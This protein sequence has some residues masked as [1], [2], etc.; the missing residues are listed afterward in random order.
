MRNLFL[1]ASI[2]LSSL[3]PASAQQSQYTAQQFNVQPINQAP[4]VTGAQAVSDFETGTT[5]RYYWIITHQ[6]SVISSPVQ[7]SNT[8]GP[9]SLSSAVGSRVNVTWN[10]VQG[11]ATYDVL[12]T[13]TPSLPLLANCAC[14]VAIGITQNAVTDVGTY[15]A[16]STLYTFGQNWSVSQ[17]IV[18]GIP[19]YNFFYNGILACSINAA[20]T[21]TCATSSGGSVSSVGFDYTGPEFSIAN[22]PV[23]STG[24]LTESKTV[25][26]P[27]TVWA[28]PAANSVNGVFDNFAFSI[29]STTV[30]T[31]STTI[32]PN[33]NRDVEIFVGET[34]HNIGQGGTPTVTGGGTW[35]TIGTDGNDGILASQLLTSTAPLTATI[36]NIATPT[37]IGQCLV[38]LQVQPAA[39]PV[40]SNTQTTSGAITNGTTLAYT[41]TAAGDSVMVV[42]MGAPSNSNTAVS[43]L[44]TDDQ[45]T[46][47]TPVCSA[48]NFT[49][50]NGTIVYVFLAS[51]V[52]TTA[53]HIKF[54]AVTGPGFSGSFYAIEISELQPSTGTSGFRPL[55]TAD[56]PVA[57]QSLINN[58]T[59]ATV[60]SSKNLASNVAFSANTTTT[61]DSITVNQAGGAAPAFPNSTATFRVNVCY[62]YFATAGTGV[63]GETEVSDGT[64][65]WAGGGAA[66]SSGGTTYTSCGWSPVTYTSAGVITFTVSVRNTG[67]QTI[68]T[69]S[70][71]LGQASHMSV[72]VI[73]SN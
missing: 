19:T 41:P 33:Y 40:F 24:V 5:V 15:S 67:S 70:P 12:E 61:I 8:R 45:N 52:T 27:N 34:D 9:A 69:T 31:L 29:S 35:T 13:S 68:S 54:N 1:I 37:N 23:T 6:N 20:G 43:Y 7:T 39:T 14:A 48:Q 65:V 55:V 21:T 10:N 22:S 51:N 16:Y 56:M 66:T 64:N 2:F 17:S 32:T 38:G 30:T 49:G 62:S 18:S 50:S 36:G 4:Q 28:G 46:T 3:L 42:F 59:P 71:I 73:P 58:P 72:E 44:A 11:V 25:Q 60:F 63:T 47:Y 26:Q 53:R 57:L